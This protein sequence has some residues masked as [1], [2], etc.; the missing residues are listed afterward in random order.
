MAELNFHFADYD[1]TGYLIRFGNKEHLEQILNGKL[2]FTSLKKY[3]RDENKNIGD[4]NEGVRTFLHQNGEIKITFS[5]P[6]HEHGKEIDISKSITSFKDFPDNKKYVSCFSYFTMK[7]IVE[8]TIV[9]EQVLAEREWDYVLI[10]I[11]SDIFIKT[12]LDVL[13]S[14]NANFSRV[15]YLDYSKNQINLNEFTKSLEYKHQKEIRFSIQYDGE[16]S[17]FINNKYPDV[18]EIDLN[19]TFKG[20]IIPTADLSKCFTIT[21]KEP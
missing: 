16:Q 9:T 13:H 8:K 2:R 14:F 20:I 17:S 18:L 11:N 1:Q 15:Q 3:Q 4:V 21:N 12:V 10:L 7:D 5:H 6:L 19:Q